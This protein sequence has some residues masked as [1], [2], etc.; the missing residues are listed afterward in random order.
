MSI[1]PLPSLKFRLKKTIINQFLRK[2]GRFPETKTYNLR[3]YFTTKIESFHHLR[4]SQIKTKYQ[5]KNNLVV[6]KSHQEQIFLN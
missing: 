3:F 5:N 6:F 4:L 2:I 1:E